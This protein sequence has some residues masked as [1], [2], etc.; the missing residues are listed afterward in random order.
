MIILRK[1]ANLIDISVS[2]FIEIGINPNQIFFLQV[3]LA[4]FLLQTT[5]EGQP[6]YEE[7][8][9]GQCQ[10]P[11]DHSS[12]YVD[13]TSGYHTL[14]LDNDY[15]ESETGLFLVPMNSH[16]KP[17]I[18]TKDFQVPGGKTN[19]K[20]FT[21]HRKTLENNKP[22]HGNDH[23]VV[24]SNFLN[25]F[26][27]L[28]NT[29]KQLQP[30]KT[31]CGKSLVHSKT[32]DINNQNSHNLQNSQ[33]FQNINTR[34]RAVYRA[35]YQ[36]TTLN[37]RLSRPTLGRGPSSVTIQHSSP[38]QHSATIQNSAIQRHNQDNFLPRTAWTDTSGSDD[39][40]D[41]A[42]DNRSDKTKLETT[43]GDYYDRPGCPS[44]PDLISNKCRT[45]PTSASNVSTSDVTVSPSSSES[46]PE[47]RF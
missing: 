42:N 4:S 22:L 23:D 8:P 36:P 26:E 19:K 29:P 32:L 13:T 45:S 1:S 39:W 2:E 31:K 17:L 43:Q 34:P 38:F 11:S 16:N 41:V 37:T 24:N 44:P 25:Q 20:F 18:M 7:I 30:K 27:T 9:T 33:N 21:F 40:L 5:P 15:S 6:I 35:T 28:D 14:P 46:Y 10:I 3:D 12:D 47:C